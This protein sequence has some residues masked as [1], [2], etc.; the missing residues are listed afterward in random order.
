MSPSPSTRAF[1]AASVL[2]TMV[3]LLFVVTRFFVRDKTGAMSRLHAARRSS[4]REVG[5]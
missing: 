2:L 5:A 4:A 3:L 1:G